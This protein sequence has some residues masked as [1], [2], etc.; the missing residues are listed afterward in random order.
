MICFHK[1]FDPS[2]DNYVKKLIKLLKSK[3]IDSFEMESD[4][5]L[6]KILDIIHD[7]LFILKKKKYL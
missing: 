6:D 5:D 2:E 7:N 3:S 4:N 1:D